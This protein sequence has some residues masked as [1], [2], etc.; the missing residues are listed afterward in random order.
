MQVAEWVSLWKWSDSQKR[1]FTCASPDEL[2]VLFKAS[3]VSCRQLQKPQ[4][5]QVLKADA[6]VRCCEE[7]T[8]ACPGTSAL[9]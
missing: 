8:L 6:A 1:P 2:G 4:V 7:K 9:G 3:Q 5:W